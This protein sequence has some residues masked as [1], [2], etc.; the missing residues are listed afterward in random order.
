MKYWRINAILKLWD[1]CKS[2]SLLYNGYFN[3][4][5]Y[6]SSIMD[7]NIILAMGLP[8]VIRN[9]KGKRA[10]IELNKN[11]FVVCRY[12]P[13]NSVYLCDARLEGWYPVHMAKRVIYSWRK[14]WLRIFS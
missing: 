8:I 14:G 4:A 9:I 11:W 3:L 2:F 5:A 13:D 7:K 1:L 6:I 12:H 10:T